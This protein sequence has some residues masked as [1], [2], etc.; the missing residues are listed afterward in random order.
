[1]LV[2]VDAVKARAHDLWTRGE[3]LDQE[4][5]I[6]AITASEPTDPPTPYPWPSELE[7]SDYFVSDQTVFL[8]KPVGNSTL[9]QAADAGSLRALRERYLGDLRARPNQSSYRDEGIPVTDG[10]TKAS[11]FMRDALPYEDDNGLWPMPGD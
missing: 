11:V 1:V 7:L 8:K 5:H 4:L 9:V 2:I 6:V 10:N 3:P